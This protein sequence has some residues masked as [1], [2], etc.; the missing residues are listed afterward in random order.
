MGTSQLGILEKTTLKMK[1][2]CSL[3]TVYLAFAVGLFEANTKLVENKWK[4]GSG[5]IYYLKGS[6][7]MNRYD[8]QD[9]CVLMGGN[10]AEPRSPEETSE[11]NEFI[12]NEK[13]NY[14]IGLHEVQKDVWIWPSDNSEL[15]DYSN[16]CY[17]CPNGGGYEPC[18][19]MRFDYEHSWD[20]F[21][22]SLESFENYPFYALCQ[23]TI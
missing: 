22:C 19:S 5:G 6:L 4:R 10:L 17:F 9:W 11:I 14:W 18:V 1:K 12:G 8:A 15:V 23:K 2:I 20:D 21:I 13:K 7:P 16:W 3:V